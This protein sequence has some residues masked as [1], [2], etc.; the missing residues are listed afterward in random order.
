MLLRNI[1][2]RSE[3]FSSIC[4]VYI[5]DMQKVQT[6]KSAISCCRNKSAYISWTFTWLIQWQIYLLPAIRSNLSL[7]ESLRILLRS[8]WSHFNSTDSKICMLSYL[9]KKTFPSLLWEMSVPHKWLCFTSAEEQAIIGSK[10]DVD[11][12]LKSQHGPRTHCLTFG[13][14]WNKVATK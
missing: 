3:C 14:T 11:L 10:M 13:M 2:G 9:F 4:S 8:L 7:H 5:F 12:T 1:F 6:L